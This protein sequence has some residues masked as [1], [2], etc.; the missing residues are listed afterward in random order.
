M[1]RNLFHG[2]ASSCVSPNVRGWVAVKLFR[3]DATLPCYV[4]TWLFSLDIFLQYAGSVCACVGSTDGTDRT[5]DMKSVHSKAKTTIDTNFPCFWVD[6]LYLSWSSSPLNGYPYLQTRR[7]FVCYD[8]SILVGNPFLSNSVCVCRCV[9]LGEC[10]LYL[11]PTFVCI[12]RCVS[13]SLDFP[14]LSTSL[15]VSVC[16]L[17][18]PRLSNHIC[19]AVNVYRFH[20]SC[21]THNHLLV[22]VFRCP[23][24][25]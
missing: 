3:G 18:G 10:A 16:L 19:L 20:G 7:P 22:L 2:V 9:S 11:L 5:R 14:C 17:I 15:S 24:K 1:Q 4:Q 12:C 25:R 21:L 23:F 6:P 8:E 13:L